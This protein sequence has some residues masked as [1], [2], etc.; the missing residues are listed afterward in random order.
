MLI[1]DAICKYIVLFAFTT[2]I[3]MV[4][5]HYLVAK[6]AVNLPDWI[7]MLFTMVFMYFFRRAPKQN[8][9]SNAKTTPQ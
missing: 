2:Y 9:G 8:G 6:E 5:N 3:G 7:V 1:L 4:L